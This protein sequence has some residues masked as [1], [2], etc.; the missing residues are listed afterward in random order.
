MHLVCDLHACIISKVFIITSP[1]SFSR[2]KNKVRFGDRSF[3]IT[4][5]NAVK[6]CLP[7]W[8]H[9]SLL[10]DHSYYYMKEVFV[11]LYFDCSKALL[12]RGVT[13]CYS[14]YVTAVILIYVI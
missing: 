12:I 2:N 10:F 9:N 6:S 14:M 5:K 13:V 4:E 7:H 11:N 3:V 8:N 1:V